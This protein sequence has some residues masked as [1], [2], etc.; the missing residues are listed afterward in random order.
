MAETLTVALRVAEEAIEEAIAKAEEFSDSLVRHP[1][2]P[3]P[4]FSPSLSVI[5]YPLFHSSFIP[6]FFLLCFLCH[7]RLPPPLPPSWSQ[8]QRDAVMVF[9]WDVFTDPL[10]VIHCRF[11]QNV[12]M[13]VFAGEAE[14]GTVSAGPQ[15]GAHRRTCYNY[16]TKSRLMCSIYPLCTEELKEK[17]IQK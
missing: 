9:G 8:Y 7:G 17:L 2:D 4:P 13:C 12:C 1:S 10:L 5:F 11:E 3:L 14:W 6:L 16:C 15:R